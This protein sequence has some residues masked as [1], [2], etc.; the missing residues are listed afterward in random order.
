MRIFW[1]VLGKFWSRF[2]KF[3]EIFFWTIFGQFWQLFSPVALNSCHRAKR[4]NSRRGEEGSVWNKD[5]NLERECLEEKCATGE[6]NEIY[7]KDHDQNPQFDQKSY[8]TAQ[9]YLEY[10]QAETKRCD[11]HLNILDKQLKVGGFYYL[12]Y[13]TSYEEINFSYDFLTIF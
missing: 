10:V 6:I 2:W 1:T 3:S 8:R 7:K 11:E 9:K 5:D 13:E 4:A 12:I